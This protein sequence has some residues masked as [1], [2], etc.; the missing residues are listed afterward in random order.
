MNGYRGC[1]LTS[2]NVCCPSNMDNTKVLYTEIRYPRT[3]YNFVSS[4]IVDMSHSI[5]LLL[6]TD[7]TKSSY[8][9]FSDEPLLKFSH[10]NESN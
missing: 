8:W 10:R 6:I 7:I 5:F 9:N 3:C 4:I 2:I 1:P